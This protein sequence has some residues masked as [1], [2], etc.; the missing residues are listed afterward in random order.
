MSKDKK[1]TF[2]I[3]AKFNKPISRADAKREL[4]EVAELSYITHYT[5]YAYDD[6]GGA[7]TFKLGSVK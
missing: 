2:T 6:D 1:H 3:T 5:E 7:E 4:K